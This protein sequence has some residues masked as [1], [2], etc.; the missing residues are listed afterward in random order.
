[1]VRA[2]EQSQIVHHT[3]ESLMKRTH[4]SWDYMRPNKN[5]KYE[6]FRFEEYYKRIMA[7]EKLNHIPKPVFEQWIYYHHQ[8][9]NTLRN[10]AWINY[11]KVEFNLCFW[12]LEKLEQVNVIT[13]FMPYC[14]DRASYSD[15]NQ[16][17]CTQKDLQ[18]WKQ[19]GTWR[20]PPIVIEIK[21]LKTAA[22]PWSELTLPYQLVEGHTRFGYL[23][24][25]K[26]MSDSNKERIAAE[27]LIYLM[28]EK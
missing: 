17:C 5:E 6:N 13:N 8:E 9:H 27:H 10:Y 12:D 2:N 16:F 19:D 23:K 3:L 20:V 15:F 28:Q 24:S 21:S 14:L 1:M 22:P 11:E 26:N 4:H 7:N 25:L 18:V